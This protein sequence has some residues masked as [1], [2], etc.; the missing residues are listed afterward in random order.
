MTAED[1]LARTIAIV[2]EVR[3]RL[4]AASGVVGCVIGLGVLAA[5]PAVGEEQLRAGAKDVSLAGGYSMSGQLGPDRGDEVRGLHLLPHLG[6]V[7][8]DERGPGWVR[9]NFE[10]LAE[11]TLIHLDQGDSTAVGIA[12]LGRWLFAGWGRV[13]P[14]FEI[15]A[16]VLGGDVDVPG[17]SCNTN[18]ILQGGPGVLVFVAPSTAITLGYRFHHISNAHVCG[19]NLGLNSSLFVVGLSYFF[20]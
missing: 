1:L 9:G 10:L 13:R 3:I 12:F 8:T 19:D 6:F 5:T 14:Y 16:G 2:D 4:L 17:T 18:F 20:P 7:V 15:G 11:P